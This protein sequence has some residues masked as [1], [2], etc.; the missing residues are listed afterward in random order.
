MTS[1][2][3]T[4]NIE[5]NNNDSIII[6]MAGGLGSRM[7]SEVPKVLHIINNKPLII[8]IIDSALKVNPYK[9]CIVVGKFYELIK[10]TIEDYYKKSN[11][12]TI[13]YNT[14]IYKINYIIQNEPQGTGHAI[15]CCQNYLSKLNMNINRC[16]ILSGDVPF[17]KADTINR[18]LE[19]DYDS[20]ILLAYNNNPHGYGRIKYVNNKFSKIIEEKDCS[21]EEKNIKLINGGIYFFKINVL[22]NYINKLTNNNNQNEYYL[23]QIFQLMNN[24]NLKIGTT[25]INDL[26][27]ISG[28]NTKEQL[29]ELE[30]QYDVL[31]KDIK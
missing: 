9:I 10:H 25:L 11:I 12:S 14:I 16:V 3:N 2:E 27:E 8:N 13:I 15:M 29:Y 31:K 26:I 23:T 5:Y 20:N 7:K 6:I 19:N 21:D 30:T 22:I 24:D 1:N 18:L 28:I 4:N 17:I